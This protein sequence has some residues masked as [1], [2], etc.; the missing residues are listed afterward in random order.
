VIAKEQ[1]LV[2]Y[3]H[4]DEVDDQVLGRRVGRNRPE[5]LLPGRHPGKDV[6]LVG[7]FP[8][9]EWLYVSYE[10]LNN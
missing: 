1:A 8:L 5:E 7:D 3:V 2:R 4:W 10:I 6:G 9:I